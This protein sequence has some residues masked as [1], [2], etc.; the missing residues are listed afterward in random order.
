VVDRGEGGKGV[1]EGEGRRVVALVGVG[2]LG[3]G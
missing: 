1:V 3:V 2:D